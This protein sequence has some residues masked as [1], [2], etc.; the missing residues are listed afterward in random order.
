MGAIGPLPPMN[1]EE[2]SPLQEKSGECSD[3]RRSCQKAGRLWKLLEESDVFRNFFKNSVRLGTGV[4]FLAVILP[5]YAAGAA[6]ALIALAALGLASPLLLSE[7]GEKIWNSAK[8]SLLG[9]AADLLTLPKVILLTSEAF[10]PNRTK[11]EEGAGDTVVVLVHGLFHN[12]SCW[13]S[14][15]K[16]LVKGEDEGEE[17]ITR[18]DL[19]EV[20]YGNPITNE[21]IDAYAQDLAAKL[22]KIRKDRGLE[23]LNVI[24]DGHSMGGLVSAQMALKYA[25][26]AKI[27]VKRLIA[28]GTPWDRSPVAPLASWFSTCCGEMRRDH[29]FLDELTSAIN[30]SESLRGKIYTIASR[31]DTLVPL[32]SARGDLLQ[33]EEGHRT[34]LAF[35]H[36]HISLLEDREGKRRNIALIREAWREATPP[37]R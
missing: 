7:R 37:R 27:E 6:I 24:L 13:H 25:D 8:D 14:F 31:G 20:N 2:V 21:S 36:G 33:L 4:A 18:G 19:Y 32:D 29:P 17:A 11:R 28:N 3:F 35:P 22:E 34:T 15:T 1:S 23:R 5:L 16:E 12:K 26:P 9:V 10:E 30:E